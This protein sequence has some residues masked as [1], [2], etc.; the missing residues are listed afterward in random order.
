MAKVQ[1]VAL[2]PHLDWLQIKKWKIGDL[3]KYHIL[4]AFFY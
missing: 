1:Y 4:H 2:E 3:Q